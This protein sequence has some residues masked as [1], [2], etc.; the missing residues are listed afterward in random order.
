MPG[1]FL[2][3]RA[4]AGGIGDSAAAS[5]HSPRTA[6][7][8]GTLANERQVPAGGVACEHLRLHRRG[9]T[10]VATANQRVRGHGRAAEREPELTGVNPEPQQAR[11]ARAQP[12]GNIY[13]AVDPA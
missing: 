2:A 9:C 12:R 10:C 1:R 13:E 5:A 11:A 4:E 8:P 7:P 3:R 6:A